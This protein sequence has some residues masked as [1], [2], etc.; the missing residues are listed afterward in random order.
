CRH[1]PDLLRAVGRTPPTAP[2]RPWLVVDLSAVP[3]C[4][5]D[6]AVADRDGAVPKREFVSPPRALPMPLIML[7]KKYPDDCLGAALL[8]L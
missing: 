8:D 6:W 3:C 5:M 2:R 7:P 4:A 1:Q